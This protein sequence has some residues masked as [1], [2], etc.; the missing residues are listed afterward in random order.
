MLLPPHLY[1]LCIE[2]LVR[3]VFSN[4]FP[5]ALQNFYLL[6]FLGD[7]HFVIQFTKYCKISIPL[8]FLDIAI[9]S[10]ISQSIANFLSPS[11]SGTLPFCNTFHK[12]LQ[13]VYLAKFL[14]HSHFIIHFSKYCKFSISL[15]FSDIAIL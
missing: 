3:L 6:I 15:N 8:N 1:L 9:L 4:T 13:N 12:V 10:Y 7:C 14:G 2:Y 11:I 5:K